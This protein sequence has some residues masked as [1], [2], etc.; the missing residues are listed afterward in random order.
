MKGMKSAQEFNGPPPVGNYR[1]VVISSEAKQAQSGKDMISVT[2]EVRSPEEHAG[3]KVF[4]NIMTDGT[5]S[6]GGFGKQ[7]LR[8]LGIDVDS[9]DEEIPDAQIA[10][11]IL[12]AEVYVALKHEPMFG[13]NPSTGKYDVPQYDVV[14][15]KQVQRQR[16]VVARYLG[17]N[18]PTAAETGGEA[19]AEAEA[20]KAPAKA[21]APAAG[22]ATPPWQA[23]AK[24]AA[25]PAAAAK[26]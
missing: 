5:Q 21:A 4:D 25:K 26:K 22:K 20:S 6:G 10:E 3:A 14:N 8:G 18:D 24:A 9:T 23:A 15:G 16:A 1:T 19:A 7:K 13:K 12:G 11:Q 17:P 2:L